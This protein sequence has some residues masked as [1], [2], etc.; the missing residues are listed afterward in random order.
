MP[1]DVSRDDTLREVTPHA[2]KGA[3]GAC[4]MPGTA[5]AGAQ[6]PEAVGAVV[7]YRAGS[8]TDGVRGVCGSALEPQRRQEGL[9]GTGHGRQPDS[10]K[11]TVR[12]ERGAWRKRETGESDCGPLGN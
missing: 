8:I 11:P 10:G 6:N 5:Y 4:R 3:L 7:G 1:S 12:D 2:G 9:L